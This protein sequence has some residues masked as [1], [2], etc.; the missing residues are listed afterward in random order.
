MAFA[1]YDQ[2]RRG[3]GDEFLTEVREEMDRIRQNPEMYG[4]LYRR[5]RAGPI[6]RFPYVVYYRVESD[7]INV[8]AVQHASRSSRGWK[9]RA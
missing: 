3:L 1:W 9:S 5:V 6:H 7:R 2:Q 4:V 8:I